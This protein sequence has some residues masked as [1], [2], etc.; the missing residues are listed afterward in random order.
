[1]VICRLKTSA[2]PQMHTF[3]LTNIAYNDQIQICI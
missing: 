2:S 3:L 1:L